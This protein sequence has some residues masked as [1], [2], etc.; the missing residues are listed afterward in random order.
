MYFILYLQL[1]SSYLYVQ[2]GSKKSKIIKLPKAKKID[3]YNDYKEISFITERCYIPI[4]EEEKVIRFSFNHI[5][6][7]NSFMFTIY[8]N[9]KVYG[10]DHKEGFYYPEIE[11]FGENF[12]ETNHILVRFVVC[13]NDKPFFL[14]DCIKPR[15]GV[16]KKIINDEEI[17]N[18]DNN[19]NIQQISI[20]KIPHISLVLPHTEIYNS[21]NNSINKIES[22]DNNINIE[23]EEIKTSIIE[24]KSFFNTSSLIK[25]P[26]CE[27][28]NTCQSDILDTNY[29]KYKVDNNIKKV[30][31]DEKVVYRKIKSTWADFIKFT[32]NIVPT[33]IRYNDKYTRMLNE[34]KEISGINNEYDNNNSENFIKIKSPKQKEIIKELTIKDKIK[35]FYKDEKM[36]NL[37]YSILD[38]KPCSKSCYD[39]KINTNPYKVI[40]DEPDKYYENYGKCIDNNKIICKIPKEIETGTVCKIHLSL[41]E[42]QYLYCGKITIVKPPLLKE[43]LPNKSNKIGGYK[44]LIKG[45]RFLQTDDCSVAFIMPKYPSSKAIV[46]GNIISSECI[47]CIVPSFIDIIGV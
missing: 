24:N 47:E 4:E 39:I 25:L 22:N 14:P 43:V 5:Y 45:E 8:G 42:Q 10:V 41:N 23:N 19:K 32:E 33:S 17:E 37:L 2:Y 15:E 12:T 46:K 26:D 30:I 3:E 29:M 1:L 31:N 11:I 35:Q 13:S 7:H 44:L 6:W 38:P 20:Q 40:K 28:I 21:L 27:D 18:N 9:E 34:L 36:I 16:C